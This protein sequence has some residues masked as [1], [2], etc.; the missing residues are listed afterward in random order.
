VAYPNGVTTT[1]TY[2][3]LNRLTQVAATTN[4]SALAAY[5][6]SPG[7]TGNRTGVVELNGRSITYGYD[8]VYRL[9][10]ETISALQGGSFTCG[11]NNQ[12]CG[13]I[14]YTYDSVGNRKQ[15]NSTLGAIP[16]G[17]WNYDS[18]DRLS[19]DTYDD[20]GNTV[21]SAGIE[22]KYDFENH[23]VQHGDIKVVY[24]GDGNRVAK[25]VGGVT[26]AYLVD[27]NNPTGYAQVVDE[28]QGGQVT[29]TAST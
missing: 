21:W 10:S 11:A 1:Y 29:R 8:D 25:T 13:A 12:K 26:A 19:T 3:L 24:D 4:T 14:D 17:L 2:N 20:A 23:L 5:A 18:N 22:N 6:Y 16:A 28:L 9:T 27:T 7:P 15:M